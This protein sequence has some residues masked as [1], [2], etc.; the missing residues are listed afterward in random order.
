MDVVTK[1]DDGDDLA[2]RYSYLKWFF[3]LVSV[4]YTLMLATAVMEFRRRGKEY[5][6]TDYQRSAARKKL[7]KE[8]DQWSRGRQ[9][10]YIMRDTA[11]VMTTNTC[12]STMKAADKSI[13][14]F[15]GSWTAIL[16]DRLSSPH[17]SAAHSSQLQ[18]TSILVIMGLVVT[19]VSATIVIG[20]LTH[21]LNIHERKQFTIHYECPTPSHERRF[22]DAHTL[23]QR[24]NQNSNNV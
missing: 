5:V 21:D 11:L 13:T 12:I 2:Y 18:Y 23:A 20:T 15:I 1:T 14:F 3:I 6:Q 19:R 22:I 9:S 8:F 24:D 4:L 16:F 7:L 10:L 17:T